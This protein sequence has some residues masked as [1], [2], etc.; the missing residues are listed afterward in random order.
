MKTSQGP[1][2]DMTT[3][4]K[5]IN[6]PKPSL[7]GVL[8]RLVLFGAALGV[9]SALFWL[10]VL[11]IPFLLLLGVLGYVILHLQFSRFG[12]PRKPL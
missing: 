1:V 10:T 12:Q 3:D 11:L 8:L 9:I 6:P 4:G 5:F 7:G 2:I